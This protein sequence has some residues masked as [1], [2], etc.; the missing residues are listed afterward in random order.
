MGVAS[1]HYRLSSYVCGRA[2]SKPS[3]FLPDTWVTFAQIFNSRPDGCRFA[4]A[5]RYLLVQGGR[6]LAY[7]PA[8]E[9]LCWDLLDDALISRSSRPDALLRPPEALWT[10]PSEAGLI[11][12]AMCLYDRP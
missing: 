11:M 4:I 7:D 5:Q 10:G 3:P 2:C 8:R 1:L 9:W 12:K 6:G